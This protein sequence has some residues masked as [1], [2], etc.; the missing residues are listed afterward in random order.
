MT[1]RAARWADL[2][3]LDF[4][5]LDRRRAIAVLPIGATEQHGPHL[6]VSVDSDLAEAVALKSLPHT[7]TQAT[8]LVLPIIAYG[9]SNEH[10]NVAGTLSL[11]A[12]TLV[13]LIMDIG[14]SLDRTGIRRLVLLNAHGGN[15][16]V[17][18]IVARDLKVD[19]GLHVATCHWYAF[20]DA[21]RLTDPTEQSYGIHA[22]KVE[23]SAMLALKP[24]LVALDRAENFANAAEEWQRSYQHLGLSAGR[25][26]PA[27]V[28]DD[29]NAKGACGDAAAATADLGR[30][31]LETAARNFAAFLSEFARFCENAEA[32]DEGTE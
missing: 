16:P 5:A 10:G 7:T 26:R 3:R 31:L 29:L 23:T 6:P 20:N 24:D 32:T 4:A 2:S 28:M 13:H 9:R 11:S 30:T 1:H 27:W 17:L 19:L 22:G 25:G 12:Q 21:N 15:T 18:E 14:R 8:V